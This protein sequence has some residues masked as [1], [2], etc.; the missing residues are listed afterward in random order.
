MP[1]TVDSYL[2]RFPPGVRD[3]LEQCRRT[4]LAAAPNATQA[5][6]YG[7]AGFFVDGA[8]IVYLAGWKSHI[9]LYPIPKGN[10]IFEAAVAPY[11]DEKSTLRFPLDRPIPYP[12]I[13]RLV[14]ARLQELKQPPA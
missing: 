14:R 3:M 4:I 10:D 9:A 8:Y 7:V 1:A 2:T 6:K 11:R 5:I 13:D 12:L